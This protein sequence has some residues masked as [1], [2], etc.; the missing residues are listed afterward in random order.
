M[1][2]TRILEADHR[3]V[4]E[5]FAKI[6]KAEGDAR[7]PLIDEL[8]TS[9]RA[10][11]E[12]EEQTL[13][14]AMEPVTG[15]ETVEEGE[16]EHKLARKSLEDMVGLAPDGPGFGAALDAVKAGIE[17]HVKEEEGE[18]FP[19][20]RSQGA[21]V[22]EDVATPFMT[23]RVELGMPMEA[24]ALAA[25]FSK[26]ELASGGGPGRPAREER[27]DQGPARRSPRQRDGLRIAQALCGRRARSSPT[28]T[29]PSG[30]A[31]STRLGSER[32]RP[33]RSSRR[34]A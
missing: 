25:A 11:M 27:H 18:V 22:L 30:V 1:D 14:P 19:K 7:T 34:T 16:T 8:A 29:W 12:L 6:S 15:A 23:K 20:L 28:A 5:L 9:L 32:T 4:E 21:S 3:K 24:P 26:E 10:H 17:H 33:S 13:Y 31:S 2:V